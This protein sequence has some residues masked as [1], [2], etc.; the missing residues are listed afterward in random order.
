M[1]ASLV[2]SEMCIRDRG[3]AALFG[4]LGSTGLPPVCRSHCRYARQVRSHHSVSYTHL[5]LPTI[6]SV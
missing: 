2:G 1:S 4:P 5:T 3:K 6:C